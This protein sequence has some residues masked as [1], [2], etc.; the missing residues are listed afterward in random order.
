LEDEGGKDSIDSI[1]AIGHQIAHGKVVG[2]TIARGTEY[3][4]KTVE[5]LEFI[6]SQV[7]P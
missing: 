5:V 7:R 1:M 4:E 6:E 3:F 2:I